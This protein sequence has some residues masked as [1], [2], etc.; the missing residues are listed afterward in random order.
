MFGLIFDVDGVIADTERVN[1]EASIKVF[2]D[3]F[4]VQGVVRSDFEA[5]LGRGA[6][7]YVRA[8]ARVHGV[9]LS[10]EQVEAATEARQDNFLAMLRD[11]PLPA[12]PGVLEL[13]NGAMAREDFRVGIATSSTREKSKAV[14]KSA[15]VPYTQM[16]Y[17]TGSDVKNK[18]PHPELFL[19]AAEKLRLAPERCVVIEDAPNG[20]EAAKAAGCRCI[21]VTNSAGREKLMDADRVVDSLVEVDLQILETLLK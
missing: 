16:A 4:G 15:Q 10:D 8:A 17:V 7:E 5:G 21:A 19:T 20:I 14:L 9:E 11:K 12:F 6:A 13:M 2:A 1:A 3:L 18:K